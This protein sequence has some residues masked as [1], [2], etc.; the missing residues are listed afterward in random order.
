MQSASMADVTRDVGKSCAASDD[1]SKGMLAQ[2][3]PDTGYISNIDQIRE[4]EYPMLQGTKS[5]R[6]DGASNNLC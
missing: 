2:V 1:G 6:P 5:L 4:V 3:D